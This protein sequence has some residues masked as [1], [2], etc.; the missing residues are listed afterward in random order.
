MKKENTT[1]LVVGTA[2]VAGAALGAVAAGPL[3]E[4]A[5]GAVG[6]ALGAVIEWGATEISTRLLS[7]S[8]K[9][10][11]ETV[12][13][14]AKRL[15]TEKLE[16]GKTLRDDA[17]FTSSCK[18][19][20]IAEELLEGIL[21]SAQRES[22]ERKLPY[23]AT[24]YANICFDKSVSRETANILIKQAESLTYHQLV[25]MRVVGWMQVS[26]PAHI[27]PKPIYKTIEGF[28]NITVATEIFDMLRKSLLYSKGD[29]LGAGGLNPANLTLAG[30]GALLFNLMEIS[31]MKV[32]NSTAGDIIDLLIEQ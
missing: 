10:K 29:V 5:G 1:K 32:D 26:S 27:K 31:K 4:I 13:D 2:T 21:F 11:V 12:Y 28:Q 23:L 24:L 20:A 22:E 18:E 6:A 9:K 16:A 14:Y 7:K 3:G 17:F 30:H 25:I 15:I 8:E 19:R